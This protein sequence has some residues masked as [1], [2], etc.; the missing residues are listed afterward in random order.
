[1][2][3]HDTSYSIM[4]ILGLAMLILS[5][6]CL[7]AGASNPVSSN[8]LQ[9]FP[10][11]Y[12]KVV[13]SPWLVPAL[14]RSSVYQ[15]EETTLYL[16]LSNRGNVSS[17]RVNEEPHAN[18]PEEVYAARMELELERACTSAQDVSVS[19]LL[20][21]ETKNSPLEL[22]SQ[23][24][25]AG[26]LREGQVSP[27]LGFPVQIYSNTTP[28]I[29]RMLA[30]INYTYQQDVAVK[31]ASSRPQNPDIYYLYGSKSQIVPL[32]MTV[33]R[34]SGA[35]FKVVRI[36]PESIGAGS[37]NNIV[38]ITIKNIGSDS[39]RDLVAKLRPE[40][41]IYVSSDESP[42]PLLA[43]G[44][45]EELVYRVEVSKDAIPGKRYQIR[46]NLEF[47]DSLRE[48]LTDSENAY[49]EVEPA[50]LSAWPVLAGLALAA[51]AAILIM[52]RRFMPA[53]A[54]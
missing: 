18:S 54:D 33:E 5:V 48:D 26:T 32:A 22:K 3:S 10:G 23:V 46:L 9:D 8:P 42:I 20:P 39:A 35:E 15:D 6:T 52:R 36:S 17:I 13:G 2:K 21:Y 53:S 38:R 37:E 43:P 50:G 28:G 34:R 14:E 41:G 25:R 1:M 30:V 40:S 51:A 49:I 29:Y 19:L 12:Y 45:E 24:A 16:S 27:R 44:G 4:A 7:N 31:P 47:S 11:D